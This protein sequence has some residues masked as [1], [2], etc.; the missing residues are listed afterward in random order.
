MVQGGTDHDLKE[1]GHCKGLIRDWLLWERL[2]VWIW[3]LLLEK[4]CFPSGLPGAALAQLAAIVNPA[5][6]PTLLKWNGASPGSGP[7]KIVEKLFFNKSLI[8]DWL[9]WER[10]GVWIWQLLLEKACFPS[11]LPG[12]ALAQLAAIVN[13]ANKPT[14][15]KWNG[16]SP[17][18]GPWKIVEKL[19]FNKSLIRDWLLWERLGVWIWQLLLEKACFPSGLP[20]AALA[21]LAAIVNPANKPTLLKWNGA[22]PGSGPWKIVEK[23]FFNKSL[24]RDWLLW[25]RL[26]VWIWQLL[27]EKACFPSGLGFQGLLWHSLLQ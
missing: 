10:L 1:E 20:G 4:A 23:L 11:G 15:L 5:N 27:L 13:P 12:A 7:W 14:L 9:L 2:G 3:Q 22:S 8:R 6:K 16:A 19:F 21:Q 24:I 18:S 25:E 17:G 26:G